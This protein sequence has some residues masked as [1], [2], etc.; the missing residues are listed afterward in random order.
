MK[1][2]EE[3]AMVHEE[4]KQSIARTFGTSL[5]WIESL[6]DDDPTQRQ[7]KLTAYAELL[8]WVLSTAQLM[9]SL[10]EQI[11]RSSQRTFAKERQ[12][13]LTEAAGS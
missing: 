1:V 11:V 2:T 12:P 3:I 4:I 7:I 13:Y 9:Q 5:E 10:Q 6:P 8:S